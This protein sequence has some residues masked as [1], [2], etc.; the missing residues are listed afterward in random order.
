[1]RTRVIDVPEQDAMT[2]D[3]VSVKINAVVYYRVMDSKLSVIKVEDFQFAISQLSQTTMRNAC[4][5]VTLDELLGKRDQISKGIQGVVDKATDP[6]GIKI[7][8]VE[9]KDVKLPGDMIRTIAKQAEA[10]RERRAVIIKA[11]GELQASTNLIK[12]AT[13]LGKANGAMHLRT[14]Q[15]L[16][17]MSSDQTNTINFFLP[18]EVARA[19]ERG[20]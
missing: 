2:K 14:L 12:A 4:G 1:M 11:E 20:R 7:L 13:I 5:E 18:L 10:E 19:M 17:D 3:N 16:N 6:W 15:N 8:D 9:L